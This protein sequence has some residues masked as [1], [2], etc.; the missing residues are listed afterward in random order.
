MVELGDK[1][2]APEDCPAPHIDCN[3]EP[4]PGPCGA[5]LPSWFFNS[6]SGQCQDFVYGGC[7]G[8]DNRFCTEEECH[9]IC[10]GQVL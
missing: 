4:D 9:Y 6:T 8:N 10:K 2:V 5:F 1:C 7:G 3:Q